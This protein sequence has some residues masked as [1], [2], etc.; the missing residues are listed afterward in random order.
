AVFQQRTRNV[1][2]RRDAINP[3]VERAVSF[4]APGMAGM[5]R[6][7]H[8]WC[9]CASARASE[10]IHV[11]M[12]AP[13]KHAHAGPAATP[14]PLSIDFEDAPPGMGNQYSDICEQKF[15]VT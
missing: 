13:R 5:T 9:S 14:N 2:P 12:T 3:A 7:R 8:R 4:G 10:I 15:T 11:R 6:K 1:E